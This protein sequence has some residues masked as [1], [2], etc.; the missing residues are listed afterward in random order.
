MIITTIKLAIAAETSGETQATMTL[1]LLPTITTALIIV[2]P[3]T[4]KLFPKG[5]GAKSLVPQ[6]FW[7]KEKG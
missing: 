6:A 3:P 1:D 5:K 4:M 2:I 7:R